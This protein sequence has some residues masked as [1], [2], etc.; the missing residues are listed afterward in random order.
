MKYRIQ[1]D[2]FWRCLHSWLGPFQTKISCTQTFP[3]AIFSSLLSSEWP[4]ILFHNNI[5]QMFTFSLEERL[6]PQSK[7]NFCWGNQRS[8]KIHYLTLVWNN[9]SAGWMGPW[10]PDPVG[11]N[12][13]H[14]RENGILKIIHSMILWCGSFEAA[15]VEQIVSTLNLLLVVPA[16]LYKE[17]AHQSALSISLVRQTATDCL[18]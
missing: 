13:A 1:N 14:G 5:H 3:I 10:V 6:F 7:L 9:S 11:G 8:S 18:S 17:Y 15:T 16:T 12:P 4:V 2:T